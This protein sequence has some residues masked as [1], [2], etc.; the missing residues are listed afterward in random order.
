MFRSLNIGS[1]KRRPGT[2]LRLPDGKPARG[3]QR[4][5][6]RCGCRCDTS[7]GWIVAT[8]VCGWRG[9]TA[10]GAAICPTTDWAWSEAADPR[11]VATASGRVVAV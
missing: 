10:D 3:V 11:V 4:V 8:R 7:G 5:C 9:T 1:V 2:R 6:F